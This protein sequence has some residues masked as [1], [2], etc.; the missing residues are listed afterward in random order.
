[1]DNFWTWDKSDG[2]GYDGDAYLGLDKCADFEKNIWF[3]LGK[4]MWR[5]HRSLYQDHLKYVCNNILKPF[6]VGIICYLE[7]VMKMHDL[8][9][10]LPP[11]SMNV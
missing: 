3:E 11:P 9:T 1:M 6:R 10:Y 8:E 4:C 5:K 7:R 2:I